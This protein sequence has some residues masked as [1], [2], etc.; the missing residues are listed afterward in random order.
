MAYEDFDPDEL[1]AP[2]AAH[3]SIRHL[4]SIAAALGLI[5]ER[6]HVSNAH[7]TGLLETAI[8]MKEPNDSSGKEAYPGMV[9]FLQRSI[10][11]ARKACKIWGTVLHEALLSWGFIFSSVESRVYFVKKAS[12]FIILT[13]VADDLEFASNDREF[14]ESFKSYISTQ[15]DDKLYGSLNSFI[16]WELTRTA[17]G[18]KVSKKQYAIRLLSRFGMEH[19]NTVS[20]PL[21]ASSDLRP[22][23][24]EDVLLGPEEHHFYRSIV[25]ALA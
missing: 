25:G 23:N 7:L 4:V 15:F 14:I 8:I 6:G 9:C 21:A 5:L 11:G 20:T 16:R 2:V 12:S 10:Y 24:G 1:Y 18:T 19:C 13:V 17:E 3:E 22:S